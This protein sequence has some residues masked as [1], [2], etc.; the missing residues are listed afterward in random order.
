MFNLYAAD[1]S[2]ALSSCS[3][4]HYSTIHRAMFG[5]PTSD[6]HYYKQA[7]GEPHL[8]TLRI[9]EHWWPMSFPS[10][11]LLLHLTLTQAPLV[12]QLCLSAIPWGLLCAC[13]SVP[14]TLCP[15][16]YT[17]SSNRPQETSSLMALECRQKLCIYVEIHCKFNPSLYLDS[18]LMAGD[19]PIRQSDSHLLTSFET[20]ALSTA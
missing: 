3:Q 16:A 13:P 2:Y 17:T 11:H 20:P 5:T 7:A 19:S 14:M 8:S 6:T 4:H 18:L 9:I 12:H 10:S 1:C 15:G